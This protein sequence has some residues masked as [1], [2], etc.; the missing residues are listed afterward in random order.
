V[1]AATA[2]VEARKWLRDTANMRVHGTTDR[3]PAELL[4]EEQSALRPL[5]VQWQGEMPC[6]A[7]AQASKQGAS[8]EGEGDDPASIERL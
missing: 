8:G 1:D 2:N 6:S 3:I 7:V 4:G 5:A